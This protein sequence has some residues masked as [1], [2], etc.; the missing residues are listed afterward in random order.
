[1]KEYLLNKLIDWMDESFEAHRQLGIAVQNLQD[2]IFKVLYLEKI[3]NW[4]NRLLDK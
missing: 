3:C 1:M 4:L 2:E